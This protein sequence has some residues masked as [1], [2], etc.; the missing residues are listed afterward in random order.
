MFLGGIPTGFY[1][2]GEAVRREL[3]AWVSCQGEP[4]KGKNGQRLKGCV[5]YGTEF[6]SSQVDYAAIEGWF[7]V[8]E[9]HVTV[10]MTDRIECLQQGKD[11]S[12]YNRSLAQALDSIRAR[13][14][15]VQVS[16]CILYWMRRN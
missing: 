10:M 3:Y 11:T 9:R 8:L 13:S 12:K 5:Q 16:G 4:F 7:Q 1:L 15:Y 6:Y 14:D 2:V